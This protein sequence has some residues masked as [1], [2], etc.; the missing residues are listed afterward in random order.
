MPFETI[1]DTS[2]ISS[3]FIRLVL[4]VSNAQSMTWSGD[5]NLQNEVKMIVLRNQSQNGGVE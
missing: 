5:N 2:D 3:L 1:A 4:Y